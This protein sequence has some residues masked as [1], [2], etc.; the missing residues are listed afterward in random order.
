MTG[1]LEGHNPPRQCRGVTSHKQPLQE[2][3]G[4]SKT[5]RGVGKDMSSP[6]LNKHE[7]YHQENPE[8]TGIRSG[9]TGFMTVIRAILPNIRA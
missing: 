7:M 9:L 1:A 8:M 6:A 2:G 3:K 5:T 4:A